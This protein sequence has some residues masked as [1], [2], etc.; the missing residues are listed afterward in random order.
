MGFR[1][2]PSALVIRG[3]VKTCSHVWFLREYIR[4]GHVM[5]LFVCHVLARREKKSSY[6]CHTVILVLLCTL[7]HQISQ[8]KGGSLRE[9]QGF[10]SHTHALA[11]K[12]GNL[13]CSPSL[14]SLVSQSVSHRSINSLLLLLFASLLAAV[15][16]YTRV[17][18]WQTETKKLPCNHRALLVT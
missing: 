12:K 7:A 3:D 8:P 11:A 17:L 13:F 15:S 18:F 6:E 4:T 10:L 16:Y 5:L 1:S 2:P 14:V 9:K